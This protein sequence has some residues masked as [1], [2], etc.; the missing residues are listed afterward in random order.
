[1]IN[2]KNNDKYDYVIDNEILVPVYVI[3]TTH[4]LSY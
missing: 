1:M 2:Y 3:L 4:H